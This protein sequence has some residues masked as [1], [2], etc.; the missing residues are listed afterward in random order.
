MD[1]G[2]DL[3]SGSAQQELRYLF[4]NE[5][6][7]SQL[8]IF[9]QER[10]RLIDIINETVRSDESGTLSNLGPM[11]QDMSEKVSGILGT[12]GYGKH[13]EAIDHWFREIYK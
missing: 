5:R 9:L 10:K 7:K 6:V 3:L 12:M 13:Q 11:M 2:I 8:L 4:Q 1:H